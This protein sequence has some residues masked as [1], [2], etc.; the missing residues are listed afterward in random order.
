MSKPRIHFRVAKDGNVTVLDV[1]G[2]GKN[3]QDVTSGIEKALGVVD[4]KSRQATSNAYQD[5][6]PIQLTNTLN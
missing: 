1:D 4:E 5:V 6:D 3:C 2:A